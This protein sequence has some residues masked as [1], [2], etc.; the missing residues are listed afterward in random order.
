MTEYERQSRYSSLKNQLESNAYSKRGNM[1]S[2]QDS[3]P[4]GFEHSQERGAARIA[5]F[6]EAKNAWIAALGES[7]YQSEVAKNLMTQVI[8]TGVTQRFNSEWHKEYQ[9]VCADVDTAIRDKIGFERYLQDKSERGEKV[10]QE[11]LDRIDEYKIN[12][13]RKKCV[14]EFHK[15]LYEVALYYNSQV[16]KHKAGEILKDVKT[17]DNQTIRELKILRVVTYEEML[18]E[19]VREKIDDILK[20][21]KPPYNTFNKEFTLFYICE[22]H[23]SY[24]SG[25][26]HGSS[27]GSGSGSSSGGSSGSSSSSP[28]ST[29][30]NRY[31]L[32]DKIMKK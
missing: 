21:L 25:S 9:R 27:S 24:S 7:D 29:Y 5:A 26:G 11:E 6:N 31:I 16:V 17:Q 22:D 19:T 8:R 20:K 32:W 13:L 30:S 12:L 28:S 3:I 14:K 4:A 2:I 10:P 23:Y 1:Q 15:Y 18:R